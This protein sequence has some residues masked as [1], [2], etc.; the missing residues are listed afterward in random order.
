MGD[1]FPLCP[2]PLDPPLA[3]RRTEKGEWEQKRAQEFDRGRGWGTETLWYVSRGKR[4]R[5]KAFSAMWGSGSDVR[6]GKIHYHTGMWG[7]GIGVREKGQG[8]E[9]LSD[10]RGSGSGEQRRSQAYVKG[11]GS[12]DALR[13]VEEGGLGNRGAIR[14]VGKGEYGR[15]QGTEALLGMGEGKVGN[16]GALRS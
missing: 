8:T 15:E 2:P 9:P 1:T 5:T 7:R 11:V 16:R 4:K 12:R 6:K 13:H 3:L 14:H 10:V